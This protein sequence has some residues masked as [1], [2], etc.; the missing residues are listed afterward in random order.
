MKLQREFSLLTILHFKEEEDAE[1]EEEEVK[2]E[3]NSSLNHQ[4]TKAGEEARPEKGKD[5]IV[6]R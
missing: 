2:K 5:R 6:K 3:G 1:D 4:A